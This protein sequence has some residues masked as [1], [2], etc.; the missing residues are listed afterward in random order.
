MASRSTRNKIRLQL[1]RAANM[2][3]RAAE[4]IAKADAMQDGQSAFLEKT[5]PNLVIVLEGLKN[6][7]SEVRER[8]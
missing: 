2:I 1:E 3:D 5:I 7:I 4:H 6:T 8:C